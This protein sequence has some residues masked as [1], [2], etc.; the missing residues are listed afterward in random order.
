MSIKLASYSYSIS[1][2]ITDFAQNVSSRSNWPCWIRIRGP[3]W[4]WR[5]PSRSNSR[6]KDGE[7]AVDQTYRPNCVFRRQNQRKPRG[8]VSQYFRIPWPL[9]FKVKF[10]VK[11]R[12][13]R[14]RPNL[15]AEL[16]FFDVKISANHVGKCRSTLDDLD[17]WP[18]RSNSRSKDG[19]RAADQTYRP[20]CVFSTSKSAQSTWASVAVLSMTLTFDLQGQIQG[21]RTGKR[22]VDQIYWAELR[23]FDIKIS[24]NHVGKCRSTFDDL[25]LWPSRSNSRSKDGE[26]AVDQTY[27]PNC[28]FSTSKSAQTTWASVAVLSM[29][30]TFDLQGK[31]TGNTL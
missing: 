10:K 3:F 1:A 31:R 8:Q 28:V 16:R 24:A 2:S 27:R 23:V 29:T 4:P 12:G 7:R 11:G 14:C 17:L 22:A 5:W 21:Q 6:S 13:T 15:Q 19:E 18:S 30:L 26:C 9:T 25:D 20:N